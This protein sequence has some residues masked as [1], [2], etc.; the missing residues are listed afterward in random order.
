MNFQSALPFYFDEELEVVIYPGLPEQT[1]VDMVEALDGAQMFDSM[2]GVPHTLYNA[3]NIRETFKL[4]VPPI[5]R[6]SNYDWPIRPGRKPLAH[7]KLM[8]NF[9]VIHPRSFNLTRMGGQKTLSML[10]AADWLM[11][12]FPY[13][14]CRCLIVSPLQTLNLVW[15]ETIEQDLPHRTA[16][17]LHARDKAVRWQRLESRADFYIINFDGL[18]IDAKMR[19]IAG[20]TAGGVFTSDGTQEDFVENHRRHGRRILDL[21]GFSKRLAERISSDIRIVIIDEASAYRDPTT[22]RHRVASKLF[23]ENV[24]GRL[25]AEVLWPL[26]GTPCPQAPTDA[27]GLAKLI[28]PHMKESLTSFRNR[29]MAP[30]PYSLT[31]LTPKEGAY[32]EAAKLL[33]PA[34]SIPIE[35]VWDAPSS[36]TVQY[37]V[38]LTKEQKIALKQLKDELVVMMQSGAQITAVNEAAARTKYLQIA[39][40]AVYDAEHQS[41][42]LDASPRIRVLEELIENAGR[43]IVVWAPFTSVVQLLYEKFEPLQKCGLIIGQI[44]IA[45]RN[46]LIS[47]FQDPRD[48]LK[49][50]FANPATMS[51]GIDLYEANLD[52]WY[53]PVDKGEVYEQANKRLHRPG[54]KFPVTYAQ[55]IATPLEREIFRRLET[56]ES[57]QGA[58]IDAITQGKF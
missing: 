54:Q 48:P 33:S 23:N 41:H 31:R 38:E 53:G 14:T 18:E 12:Q 25:R 26:T 15:R 35:D 49:I 34:I 6:D 28:N 8:A 17:V 32:D 11:H 46:I 24:E 56:R 42:V 20:A 29:T 39:L 52:V 44:P 50:L 4:P 37:E 10:W 13:G 36:Q 40:G 30:D 2:I 51:H 1:R 3:Q 57:L 7:Q 16:M 19:K 45:Q 47:K 5:I 9:V 27:Y 22:F 21:D 58:M 43:K 55:L